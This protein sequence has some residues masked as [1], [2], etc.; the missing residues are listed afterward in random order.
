MQ[1]IVLRLIGIAAQIVEEVCRILTDFLVSREDG[2]VRIKF[3]SLII[4][5]AGSQMDITDDAV[6]LLFDHHRDFAVSLQVGH[7][8]EHMRTGFFQF[9]RPLHIVLFVETG[10]QLDQYSDLFAR[11]CCSL[12]PFD[13]R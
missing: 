1:V 12:Q 10:F 2:H 13:D 4:V 5:I 7:A 8:I 9:L 11:F 3:C 6:V